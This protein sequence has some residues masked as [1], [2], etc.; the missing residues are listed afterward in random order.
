MKIMHLDSF[1]SNSSSIGHNDWDIFLLDRYDI[2]HFHHWKQN[3]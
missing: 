3:K 2:F 1:A